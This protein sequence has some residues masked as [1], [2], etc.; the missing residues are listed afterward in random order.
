MVIN[1]LKI[2]ARLLLVAGLF[3]TAAALGT[4]I[5]MGRHAT[6]PTTLNYIA[7]VPFVLTAC[8][9]GLLAYKNEHLPDTKSM[10]IGSLAAATIQFLSAVLN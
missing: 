2:L 7:G 1:L 8:L 5:F 3:S 9:Y 4:L 6:T 10:I